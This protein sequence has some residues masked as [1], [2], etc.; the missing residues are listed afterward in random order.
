MNLPAL[1]QIA[2]AVL[3]EGFL[4]YPYRPSAVKNRRG[5]TFGA[6]YPPAFPRENGDACA[7]LTECLV[8]GGPAALV[9]VRVRFLHLQ[10]EG[11]AQPESGSPSE[12]AQDA[13]ERE[14]AIP[15]RTLRSLIAAPERIDFSFP[16]PAPAPASAPSGAAARGRG[17]VRCEALPGELFRLAVAIENHAELD[18]PRDREAALLRTVVSTHTLLGVREGEFVSLLEPPEAARGAAAGCRNVGAWAVVV[19]EAG[20]RGAV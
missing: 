10:P 9:E 3:Y 12:A 11:T 2:R 1:E 14:V 18:D 17:D 20:A 19:G 7:M 13:V 6:L 16:A 15:E 5:W 4:L 8:R